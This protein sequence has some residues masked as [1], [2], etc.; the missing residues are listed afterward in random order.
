VTALAATAFAAAAVPA[1]DLYRNLYQVLSYDSGAR[2]PY[3][4]YGPSDQLP[5]GLAPACT[6]IGLLAVAAAVLIAVRAARVGP[7]PTGQTSVASN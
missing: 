5:A 4:G 6:G 3:I 7:D 1:F 2:N